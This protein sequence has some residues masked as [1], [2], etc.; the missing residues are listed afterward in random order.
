M[1]N[2]KPRIWDAEMVARAAGL[3]RAGFPAKVIA[4]RLGVSV[5]AVKN[6]MSTKGV[7]LRLDGRIGG[8]NGLFPRGPIALAKAEAFNEIRQDLIDIKGK[9]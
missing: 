8:N 3:K 1:A 7:K 4:T 6:I 2:C 5:S 9:Q